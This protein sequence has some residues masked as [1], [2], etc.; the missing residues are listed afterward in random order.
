MTTNGG[1][2][3]VASGIDGGANSVCGS[4]GVTAYPTMVLIG[5][6]KTILEQDM[7]SSSWV[8]TVEGHGGVAQ[9]CQEVLTADFTISPVTVV[10]GNSITFDDESLGDPISW[11]WT[12]DGGIPATSTDTVVTVLYNTVGTYPVTLE[13]TDGID[14]SYLTQ[15][16]YV[17]LPSAPAPDFVATQTTIMVGESISFLDLT[18]GTPTE[19]TWTFQGGDP[20][21]S[22]D[23]NPS[24]VTYNYPG[25][26]NVY[27]TTTNP[28]GVSYATKYDYITVLSEEPVVKVCDTITNLKPLDSLMVQSISPWGVVPGHNALGYNAYADQYL[29]PG[30]VY[31]KIEGLIAWVKLANPAVSTLKVKF[32]V[33]DG[34]TAPGTVLGYKE[35]L[36]NSLTPNFANFVYFDSPITVSGPFWVGYELTYNGQS[37]FSCSM[38]D[39]RG[40]WGAATMFVKTGVNWV[41]ATDIPLLNNIHTSLGVEPIV[42]NTTGAI[43]GIDNPEVEIP[44]SVYPNPNAGMFTLNLEQS[45]SGESLITVYNLT[46]KT[47]YSS[48]HTG[49]E[50]SIPID[51][52]ELANGVYFVQLENK[53]G[54]ATRKIVITKD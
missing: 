54:I 50:L 27:L 17:V 32:S 37:V 28:W 20:V 51:L 41:P 42:C 31:D 2:Y 5:P 29:N 48:A 40:I 36:I 12:F 3:P 44:V 26:Y 6:D 49:T 15:Y 34:A 46:G 43:F 21:N 4:Y 35:V 16:V 19:W 47:V 33:W 7:S 24:V 22:I 38:A 18:T 52:S 53:L 45:L 8:T 39:D 10:F 23:Q 30:S 25:Q 13:V 14:T 11:H 1:T 9:P